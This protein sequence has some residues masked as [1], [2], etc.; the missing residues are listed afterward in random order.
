M[1]RIW[2]YA[3]MRLLTATLV[4]ACCSPLAAQR[5]SPQQIPLLRADPAELGL[6]IPD[7]DPQP[8][9]DRRVLIDYD[10]E[11]V[12]GKV[13]VEVGGK[14]LVLLP[15]GRIISKSLDEA[16]I[17]DRPFVPATVKTLLPKLA[18][19]FPGFKTQSTKHFIYIY[20]TSNLFYNGTS[21]ILETM[22]PGLFDYCKK[23]ELN[24]HE[25]EYPLVVIMFRTRKQWEDYMHGMFAGS[26]VAAFYDGVSNRVLMYEQSELGDVAPEFA[27]KEIISTVAHEG[28]HQ[29]LHNIGVQRRMSRWPIWIAEGLPEYFA[30]T[31]VDSNLKWK[32]TG[33]VNDLRM[34]SLKEA[35][36]DGT[37][38]GP[39]GGSLTESLIAA[40]RI[41]ADGYAWS[42]ALTHYLGEKKSEP[43]RKFL[44]DVSKL[45]P[46]LPLDAT[47]RRELFIKHFG[48]D[49]AQLDRDL[50][51][52]IKKLPFVDPIENMTHYVIMVNLAGKRVCQLT[53][54]RNEI[55]R[56][57]QMLLTQIPPSARS[58]V[59]FDV[60]R[61]NTRSSAEKF[62]KQFMGK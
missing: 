43:F 33:Q 1:G 39:G 18:K 21:R 62:A 26:G 53:P 47:Q 54:S 30:P 61:F 55:G 11:I 45:E 29:I 7:G 57:E 12:V 36:A 24:V 14:F 31:T 38:Q 46:L 37:P 23:H 28:V 13:V 51:E 4:V 59:Q 48:R 19:K 6:D 8:A 60:K 5:R 56:V 20:N 34:L 41:D 9:A 49:F 58:A 2:M 22:Y 16:T 35:L 15:D 44:A 25:P 50:V 3:S 27:L 17:T 52:H 40:E 42:W 10:D 32:G